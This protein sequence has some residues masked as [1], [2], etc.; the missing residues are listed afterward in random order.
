M[1]RVKDNECGQT[2]VSTISPLKCKKRAKIRLPRQLKFAFNVDP[3]IDIPFGKWTLQ[4][5]TEEGS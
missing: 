5:G 3:A 1:K 2:R 4:E